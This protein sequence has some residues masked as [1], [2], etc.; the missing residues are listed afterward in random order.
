[1]VLAVEVRQPWY[2]PSLHGDTRHLCEELAAGLTL[3]Q[4]LDFLVVP[5]EPRTRMLRRLRRIPGAQLYARDGDVWPALPQAAVWDTPSR[6]ATLLSPRTL[7]MVA[8]LALIGLAVSTRLWDQRP[9]SADRTTERD[10]AELIEA[11]RE[12][13]EDARATAELMWSFIDS[14]RIDEAMALAPTAVWLNPE[15]PYVH[16]S[17]GWLRMQQR[18]FE[19]AIPSFRTAIQLAPDHEFAHLNLGFALAALGRMTDAEAAFREAVRVQPDNPHAVAA[20]AGT[21]VELRRFD[22]AEA[23]VQ[24]ALARAPKSAPLHFALGMILRRRGQLDRALEALR[25]SAR[26][27][28]EAPGAWIEIGIIHH[29]NGDYSAA[30]DALRRAQV[31]DAAFFARHPLARDVLAASRRGRPYQ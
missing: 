6:L 19:A 25:E 1:V 12:N 17:L 5:V 23:V 3:P 2:K 18:E 11:V 20:Q 14:G 22:D 27:A 26:L 24:A 9:A 16:N 15:D 28:P 8:G 31:I 4:M 10:H 29:V 7:V 21:L 30:V 13:P